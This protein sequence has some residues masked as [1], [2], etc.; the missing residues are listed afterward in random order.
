MGSLA[1]GYRTFVP[2][3]YDSFVKGKIYSVIVVA[4]FG[5]F[6]TQII[7]S[8]DKTVKFSGDF[9]W[10]KDG[11]PFIGTT[12]LSLCSLIL[13]VPFIRIRKNDIVELKT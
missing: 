3:F 12:I 10:K 2:H 1:L 11:M 5:L 9:T 6:I 8:L 7:Y 4:M 13:F